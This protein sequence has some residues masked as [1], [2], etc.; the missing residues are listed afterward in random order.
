MLRLAREGIEAL[1]GNKALG[2]EDPI[3]AIAFL[4]MLTPLYPAMRAALL[5]ATPLDCE[6]ASLGVESSKA[7]SCWC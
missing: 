4:G 6:P 7:S 1:R 5:L 2:V 3:G